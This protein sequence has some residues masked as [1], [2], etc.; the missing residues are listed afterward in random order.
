MGNHGPESD[1]RVT[2][3]G[4]GEALVQ[5]SRYAKQE[6]T[7]TDSYGCKITIKC[8]EI[9]V[10]FIDAFLDFNLISIN[11]TTISTNLLVILHRYYKMLGPSIKMTHMGLAHLNCWDA[12]GS[13]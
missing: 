1:R 2:G 3:E 6:D 5:K 12:F 7:G 13:G 9:V 10:G 11:P 8:V 4:E